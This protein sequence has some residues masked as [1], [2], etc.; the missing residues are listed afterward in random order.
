[1]TQGRLNQLPPAV[2]RVTCSGETHAIRWEG[3]DLVALNHDDP[4]GERTLAALGGQS[5]TCL[6]VLGAWARQREDAALLSALSRET[7][8]PVRME[9][10]EAGRFAAYP[11]TTGP[12][13]VV[14]AR[15]GGMWRAGGSVHTISLSTGVA[16]PGAAM[17]SPASDSSMREQDL[18]L[19]AG[20]GYELTLRMVA[21][22][23]AALLDRLESP[24]G[25]PP[26]PALVASTFGRASS[27][28]RT[29]LGVPELAVKL[30]VTAPDGEPSLSWEAGGP[31]H[32]ALPLGWVLTIWSRD[33]TVVAG[34]FCLGVA[35]WNG[36]RTTLIVLVQT[37][38]RPG[39]SQSK[40]PDGSGS[41]N[42][43]SPLNPSWCRECVLNLPE[44]VHKVT[45][46]RTLRLNR[47]CAYAV[48]PRPTLI[49]FR[50]GGPDPA[51][52]GSANMPPGH[53]IGQQAN[54][55]ANETPPPG[56]RLAVHNLLQRV[57]C[58][59]FA[60]TPKMAPPAGAEPVLRRILRLSQRLRLA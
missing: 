46:N 48:D 60:V 51:E 8:D 37:S 4:E 52:T 31:L 12:R 56:R 14:P 28:L 30:E 7:H 11:V 15:T 34:R 49:A 23:T 33:L 18:V 54:P 29:W 42:P 21:T 44:D 35:E 5:C 3:G 50:S 17:G 27:A 43:P 58:V 10:F 36:S 53:Q 40:S 16:V 59:A 1:M 19:L 24:H 25:P 26:R 20:L 39:L 55:V 57:K 47:L 6:D 45:S 32:L 9:G 22:V 38:V 2:G 41:V 13:N